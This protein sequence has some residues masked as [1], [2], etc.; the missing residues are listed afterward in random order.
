MRKSFFF[1]LCI[2]IVF[3]RA[4]SAQAQVPVGIGTIANPILADRYFGEMDYLN[5]LRC[6]DNTKPKILSRTTVSQRADNGHIL[7][8]FKVECGS[9]AEIV[10][11]MY[12]PGARE[13]EKV[14]EGFNLLRE[15]PA[16]LATGC[17]PAVV[18]DREKDAKYIFSPFEVA[19]QAVLADSISKIVS[20]G[21]DGVAVIAFVVDTTGGVSLS[22]LRVSAVPPIPDIQAAAAIFARGLRFTPA[23]HH[24]GCK[25]A[26]SEQIQVVFRK[27]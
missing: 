10:I 14:P 3:S 27:K 25:V 8:L 24:P 23:E 7:D 9:V 11:D 13:L 1:M 20:K 18:G 12:H 2:S 26:Q 16:L 19:Q 22:S 4:S 21:F 17:P 6:N 5:R 15:L